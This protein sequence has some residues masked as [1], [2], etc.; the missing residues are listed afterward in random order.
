MVATHADVAAD[1]APGTGR[2]AALDTRMVAARLVT[3]VAARVPA[4]IHTRVAADGGPC[5]G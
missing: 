5:F 1:G 4:T 2:V 3:A